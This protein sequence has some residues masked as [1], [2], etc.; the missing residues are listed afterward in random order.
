MAEKGVSA[1]H[2]PASNMKLGSGLAPVH[3]MLKSGV[4]VALGTDGAASNNRLSMFRELQLAGLIHKGFYRDPSLLSPKELLKLSSVNGAAAQGRKL[5]GEVRE[6]FFADLAILRLDSPNMLPLRDVADSI[7][8]SA[9]DRDIE[10]VI[11][12][13]KVVYH[14][15]EFKTIDIERAKWKTEQCSGEIEKKLCT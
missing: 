12:R 10:T 9:A 15:N 8:Y 11:C 1:V 2:C 7:V 4:R 5:T 6:G 3:D 14:K 13:G